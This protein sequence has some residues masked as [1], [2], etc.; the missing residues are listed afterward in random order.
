[1]RTFM[2]VWSSFQC[3]PIAIACQELANV[4]S[5][6]VW[7][8]GGIVGFKAFMTVQEY[9]FGSDSVCSG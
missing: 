7:C 3:G 2:N 1:M 4:Q 5:R 8:S 9:G 6:M